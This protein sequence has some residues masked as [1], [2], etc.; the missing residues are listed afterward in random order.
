MS[1]CSAWRFHLRFCLAQN[2]EWPFFSFICSFFKASFHHGSGLRASVQLREHT[3]ETSPVTRVQWDSP[4]LPPPSH[5]FPPFISASLVRDPPRGDSSLHLQPRLFTSVLPHF[6]R[7]APPSHSPVSLVCARLPVLASS[8]L[9]RLSAFPPSRPPAPGLPSFLL[10]HRARPNPIPSTLPL[11]P[12][13]LS[14][15]ASSFL[16]YSILPLLPLTSLLH[17]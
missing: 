16:S 8:L 9:S 10:S 17:L 3:K 14:V 13:V 2:Q 12:L 5:A 1:P 6:P 4:L 15:L 11:F 7:L